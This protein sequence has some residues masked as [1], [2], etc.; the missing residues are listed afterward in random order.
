MPLASIAFA[1]QALDS[2]TGGATNLMAYVGLCTASPGT[3]GANEVS[4]GGYSRQ[5]CTWNGAAS[6]SKT[7]SSTLTFTTSGADRRDLRDRRRTGELG[8][9]DHDHRRGRR[10]DRQRG[11]TEED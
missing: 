2:G 6:G 9:R 8:D 1:N 5:A 7:N 4:G 10:A 3:T 11:L